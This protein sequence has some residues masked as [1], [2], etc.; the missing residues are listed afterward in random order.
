VDQRVADA[1]HKVVPS[2]KERVERLSPAFCLPLCSRSWRGTRANKPYDRGMWGWC[3]QAE[4]VTLNL[5]K[6][7]HKVFYGTCSRAPK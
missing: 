3:G 5:E 1:P 4:C 6:Y 2:G 7:S